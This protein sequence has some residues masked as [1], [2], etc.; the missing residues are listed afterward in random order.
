MD[1]RPV[2][3]RRLQSRA[4]KL[5]IGVVWGLVVLSM[6]LAPWHSTWTWAFLIALPVAIGLSLLVILAPGTLTTRIAIGV[7]FMVIS[8]LNIHQSAGMIELHFGIF[9]LLAF[10]LCY[11]DWRPIVVAA[12]VAAIHHL[13]FNYFQ[14]LGYGVMCFTQTGLPIV[15]THAA[16]VVAETAVLS[17]LAVS[18]QR[19]GIQAVELE[20]IVNS[21]VDRTGVIN[22]GFEANPQSIAGVALLRLIHE[23]NETMMIVAT[24]AQIALRSSVDIADGNQ[25][26]AV[27]TKA[28]AQALT[29]TT[30]P[31][32]ALTTTVKQNASQAQEAR[33]IVA[34]AS[35]VA[36]QGGNAVTQIVVTMG[37]INASSR[38]ISNIISVIDA[39]AF[40][41]NLLALNAAVEAARAGDQ[42]RGFAVVAAEVRH[43]AQRSADA[44][45]EIKT[46]IQTSV[47]SVESGEKLVQ[48]ARETMDKVVTSV[49]QLATIM[50]EFTSAFQDQSAGID[51]VNA[52]V[53]AMSGITR[54]N[55]TLV[56]NAAAIAADLRTHATTLADAV[57][58][59]ASGSNIDYANDP[60]D[61]AHLSLQESRMHRERSPL[62]A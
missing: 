20:N 51:Q 1:N 35:D 7:A 62:A 14:E 42:G 36:T 44:A 28:Q 55:G 39:I 12:A 52:A 6:A 53:A 40:Q 17:Y 23:L 34:S 30:S 38:Q 29:D 50:G 49:K 43:L 21:V 5:M 18:L 10:L 56:E 33:N 57:A 8:A 41:T 2:T 13:S 45:R 4:D 19:E 9:V 3:L 37:E 59:F 61:R 47:Q 31:L 54:E 15:L 26:L 16:Y 27:Q 48:G 22:L 58:I 24:G 11:R 32:Q 46:L 60:Q 25:E